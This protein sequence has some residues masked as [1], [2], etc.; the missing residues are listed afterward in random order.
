METNL[1]VLGERNS[2]ANQFLFELRHTEVQKDRM[3][4][5]KN[6][7][8][9]G[10]LLAYEVSRKLAYTS[11]TV[12]T[13]LGELSMKVLEEEP[14]L[15]TVLR[16][17]IPFHQGFLNVFD[18]ADCGFIGA[19]RNEKEEGMITVNVDYLS[20]PDVTAKPVVIID[21]MLATGQSVLG[22]YKL[23]ISKGKPSHIF[24]ASVVAAPEGIDLLRR[25]LA[26][27][28]S[29]WTCALDEKLNS[30]FYIIPGL[31]DAGDLSY[32]VKR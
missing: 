13:P 6:L 24:V 16:A 26:L 27:P 5:R 19:Y 15:I 3:R 22:A 30:S 7:E 31:G 18:R 10:E 17:G 23:L 21:P 9:L 25:S 32:G 11:R 29:L 14:L 12:R 8:R 2:I 4:F 1:F 28:F 20:V